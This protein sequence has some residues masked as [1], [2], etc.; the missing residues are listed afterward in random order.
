[1]FAN[2][3]LCGPYESHLTEPN[4]AQL[5]HNL[6]RRIHKIFS[7]SSEHLN[8]W[9]LNARC[10][11]ASQVDLNIYMCVC[12]CVDFLVCNEIQWQQLNGKPSKPKYW[13]IAYTVKCTAGGY[14]TKPVQSKQLLQSSGNHWLPHCYTSTHYLRNY[15]PETHTYLFMY[16]CMYA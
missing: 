4:W 12:M 15:F 1:M 2:Y 13:Q 7:T 11:F 16:I 10:L 5:Y 14:Y 9:V 6:H 3:W 8:N